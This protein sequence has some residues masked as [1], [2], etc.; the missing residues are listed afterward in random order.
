MK[1]FQL[2]IY[3]MEEGAG[4]S[5]KAIELASAVDVSS[6]GFFQRT[7]VQEF[8]SFFA[9]TIAERTKPGERQRVEKDNTEY[10]GYVYKQKHDQVA[11][12]LLADKEYPQ[13]VAFALITKMLDEFSK[14]YSP[15]QWSTVTKPK[16]LGFD[17][18]MADYLAKYQD[19]RQA[20]NIMQ[21]HQQL[22]ETK[23]VLHQTIEAVLNREEK[24]DDLISKSNS[25]SVQSQAFYQA[26]KKTNKC[27]TIM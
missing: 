26:A 9:H 1:V 19:P 18:T 16:S 4:A 8:M 6:F 7:P 15:Q 13:R 23:A 22:D 17:E 20:D 5:S 2:G 21:I 11:G 25:L 10:Y 14:K 27:C 12:V 3:R 24:L